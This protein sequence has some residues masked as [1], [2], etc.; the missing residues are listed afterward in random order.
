MKT[1]WLKSPNKNYLGHWDIP[2]G[3][4]VVLTIKGASY[5]EVKNPITREKSSCRVIRFDENHEWVKP[6]ICN[7]TNA[8]MIIKTTGCKFMEDTI[9]KK[10]KLG[11]SKTKVKGDEIDCI[12]VKRASQDDLNSD[13]IND[14]QI[15]ELLLWLK[16]ANK[17]ENEFCKAVG[18]KEVSQV[19]KNNF[20]PYLKRLKEISDGN[21]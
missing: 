21:N 6:F 17:T 5:E 14:K 7:Q 11:V 16:K 8:M 19:E 10:I 4:D 1:H 2:N 13:K 15:N 9:G 18:I 12:R 3:D 20:N